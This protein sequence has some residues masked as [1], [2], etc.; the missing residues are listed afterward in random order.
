MFGYVRPFRPE[1]KCKDY[2][3]YRA[4]YC[5]LCRCLRRRYGLIAPMLL[6]FDF[7]FLALLLWE[8]EEKFSPCQGRCHANPL[9][10]R[11]MCPDSP[12]LERA[13]DESVVLAWWQL[14]D[15]AQD[16][17]F[18]GGLPA[19][20]LSWLLRPAYKKAARRCPDFDGTARRCLAEL[21]ALER[22]NCP[23]LDRTADAFA[24]ILQSAAEQEGE[25]GRVL[26]QL[27]YHLGRWI[28][29]ADARD[30]LEEDKLA[31]RYNPVAA[32][33]GP[34]GDDGA[35][36][37]TMDHSLELVGAALQLGEFGCRRPLLENIVYLGLPLVQRAV[38][39]GSWK[40]IKKHKIWRND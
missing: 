29:L 35:L 25:Q 37:L 28:Y 27:L 21:S 7:T 2:D 40:E 15:S 20:S 38:F 6:N 24:R 22:D 10:K 1:L 11:P 3:L 18:W 4:T 26:S 39:D 36:G 8:P 16:D 12:A 30:D 9:L 34:G 32:R 13:A 19:R 17:G 31:R 5:G 33:Y 23:S 14:R